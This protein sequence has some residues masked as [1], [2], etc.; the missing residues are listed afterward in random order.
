MVNALWITLIG[1]SLVF[2]A[3]LLLWGLMALLVL[4]TA[5]RT[6][7]VEDQQEHLGAEIVEAPQLATADA[8]SQ[9]QKRRAAAAAVV[10]ALALQK[11]QAQGMGLEKSSAR[12]VST[13]QAVHRA[14][15]LSRR[16]MA[17]RNR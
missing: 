7:P 10:V 16:A 4:L 9:T 2:V 12:Q 6:P 17:K 5:G 1:M 15:E 13:W 14:G 11:Q 8:A 3:I